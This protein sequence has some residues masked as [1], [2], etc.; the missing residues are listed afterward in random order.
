MSK[1][2]L[3]KGG[4]RA[5]S[6]TRLIFLIFLALCFSRFSTPCLAEKQE[7]QTVIT[8]DTLEYSIKTST[9]FATGNVNVQSDGTTVEAD[10]MTYNEQTGDITAIGSVKY[11]D[12]VASIQASRAELNINTKTGRLYDAEILFVEDNYHIYG[13]QIEKKGD[14]YYVSPEASFTTCDGPVPAWCFKGRDINLTA[15]KEIKARDVSFR[16]KDVP[17]LYVPYIKLPLL[18]ERQTGFLIP[19]LGYSNTRGTSVRVPFFWAISGNRDA[20]FIMDFYSKRG[21]GEG[22]EYRYIKPGD[23]NG[24]MWLYHIR[25]TSLDKDFFEMK[26]SHKQRNPSGLGGYLNINYVNEKDFFREFELELETRSNRFLESTGEISL[27]LTNSRLYLLAQYLVDLKSGT[28]TPPQKLPEAGFVIHP[29]KLGD[30]WVSATAAFSNFWRDEGVFGQR[31]DIYPRIV[32]MFGQDV[33]VTQNLGVLGSAYSLHRSEDDFLHREN[34]DYTAV[35]KTRLFKKYMSFTHILEPSVSYR[36]ISDRDEAP[37]FDSTELIQKTSEIELSLL[38]RLIDEKGEFIVM[39]VS[40]AYDTYLHDRPF[41]PLKLQVGIR[42]PILLRF[43]ASYDVHRGELESI[44]SDLF[45]KV[46]LATLLVGQRYNRFNDIS[47]I[48]AGVGIRPFKTISLGGRAWYDAE[49]Q[50]VREIAVNMRYDQKCWGLYMEF[51]K[52]PG[53]FTAAVMFD[54]KGISGAL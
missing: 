53:D 19:S 54:L 27:P 14:I 51:Y 23:V 12:P 50:E 45:V 38:N 7:K 39:K 10:E 4:I 9:Y 5:R 41:L 20:T 36:F 49:E 30:F 29:T 13:R 16:I 18:S 42:R 43:D 21:F 33:V 25:D 32:H 26:A 46:S 44:N 35:A 22:L 34:F 47:T 17:V 37:L 31:L 48:V 1:T 8:S 28:D 3:G 40:Q 52:R 2:R 24:T 15:G 11:K 6:I